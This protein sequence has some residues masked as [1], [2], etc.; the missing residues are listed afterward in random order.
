MEREL[1]PPLYRLLREVA[2]D[3]HQKYVHMQPWIL[4]DRPPLGCPP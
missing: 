1:W 4:V 2:K 3:F